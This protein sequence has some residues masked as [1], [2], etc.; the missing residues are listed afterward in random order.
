MKNSLNSYSQ[1][2]ILFHLDSVIN[3]KHFV[4]QP[5]QKIIKISSFIYHCHPSQMPTKHPKN[6]C[7]VILPHRYF[8][9]KFTRCVS[10]WSNR[11]NIFLGRQSCVYIK[12][13]ISK[14]KYNSKKDNYFSIL[15]IFL[16]PVVGY[17]LAHES[18]YIS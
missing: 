8:Y 15:R 10:L 3:S 4:K 13:F 5:K 7:H 14:I 12:F 17:L 18:C 11:S 1:L 16:V 6:Q 9:H 2:V